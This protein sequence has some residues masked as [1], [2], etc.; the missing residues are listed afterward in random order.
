M[1]D[2]L[3]GNLYKKCGH[4]FSG[5]LRRSPRWRRWKPSLN[6]CP[7]S[8]LANPKSIQTSDWPPDFFLLQKLKG[9]LDV[10]PQYVIPS[11][12]PWPLPLHGT[13][14][15]FYLNTIKAQK[16]LLIEHYPDRWVG[17]RNGLFCRRFEFS[18]AMYTL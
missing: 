12:D 4:R 16:D 5:V 10:S 11:E 15:G 1:Q 17:E 9:H 3:V 6:P 8:A 7:I 13:P 14:V 18:Q 2:K